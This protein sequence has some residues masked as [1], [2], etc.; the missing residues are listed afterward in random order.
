MVVVS[1]DN[2]QNYEYAKTHSLR[3]WGWEFIKRNPEYCIEWQSELEKFKERK[4][5]YQLYYD[6]MGIPA[7]P[8]NQRKINEAAFRKMV[9]SSCN[10]ID[11]LAGTIGWKATEF[12]ALLHL[13]IIHYQKGEEG[14]PYDAK[15]LARLACV[16]DKVWK[17]ISP[18]VLSK[19]H[20]VPDPDN[21]KVARLVNERCLKVIQQIEDKASKNS[22]NSRKR[23]GSDEESLMPSHIDGNPRQRH[24]PKPLLS[25]FIHNCG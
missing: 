4:K 8:L 25:P 7:P 5:S 24:K 20:I 1:W 6:L 18:L 2:P 22:A 9:S 19:F 12:G 16:S 11:L 10:E 13:L 17:T 21:S 15:T 14:L 23:W 3:D